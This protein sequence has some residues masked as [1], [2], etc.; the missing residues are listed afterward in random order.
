M[1]LL[2]KVNDNTKVGRQLIDAIRS[3]KKQ[4]T[5]S[6]LIINE[7][8]EFGD[9]ILEGPVLTQKQF[10]RLTIAME[11]DVDYVPIEK[12]KKEILNQLQK[13]IDEGSNKKKGK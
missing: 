10:D 1:E 9:L 3:A 6:V 4:D 11:A 12:A 5:E 2:V 13:K 8:E 7:E